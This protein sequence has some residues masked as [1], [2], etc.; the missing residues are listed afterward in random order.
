MRTVRETLMVN[1]VECKTIL[2]DKL[3]YVIVNGVT[4]KLYRGWKK[5]KSG[6]N[7]RSRCFKL[8]SFCQICAKEFFG[9]MADPRK[10][11]SKSCGSKI[12]VRGLNSKHIS[13][14]G[15]KELRIIAENWINYRVER[16]RIIPPKI[17]SNCKSHGDMH[18]HHPDY[19]KFNE[20]I[21]LCIYCHKR[22]HFGH[23]DIKGKLIVY[24]I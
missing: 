15:G 14:P 1:D 9:S 8:K 10:Y 13:M 3:W 6:R 16:G 4:C 17:C 19:N 20:V 24:N 22:V 11:C 12:S 7:G 21:W 23:K 5:D 18:A 2:I